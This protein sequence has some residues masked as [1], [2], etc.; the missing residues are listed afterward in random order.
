MVLRRSTCEGPNSLH[1]A[2][3]WALLAGVVWLLL[4]V[5]AHAQTKGIPSETYRYAFSLY[6]DGNYKDA[7]NRFQDEWRSANKFGQARWIDSICYHTM[8]GECNYQ[9]GLLPQALENYTAAIHLFL[10]YS[11]WMTRVQFRPIQA[12]AAGPQAP[13]G[14][15]TRGSRMGHYP[16]RTTMILGRVD[17]TLQSKGIVETPSG[18]PVEVQEIVRCTVLAIRRRAELLGPLSRYDALNKTLLTAV[19]QPIGPRNHWAQVYTDMELA[20]ALM[21]NGKDGEAVPV[22]TRSTVAGGEYDHP[23]T[24]TALLLLGQI[25]LRQGNNAVAAKAFFE[26]TI[27]AFRSEDL[28]SL[29]VIEE[30][31]HGASAA[32]LAANKKGMYPPLGPAAQWAQVKKWR[33]LHATLLLAAAEGALAAGQTAQANTMLDEAQATMARR[34]MANGRIGAAWNYL[35]AVSFFQQRKIDAGDQALGAAMNYLRTGSHWLFHIAQVDAAFASSLLTSR[36]ALDLYEEVLRDPQPADWA[37]APA[38]SLAVLSTPHGEA[39]ERWFL[40]ALQRADREA[41]V[42]TALEISDRARRHRFFSTLALGGRLQALR[43]VLEAPAEALDKKTLA[44]RLDLLADF[45]AYQALQQQV[46]QTQT[47]LAKLPLAPQDA[48]AARQQSALFAE[49]G[50]LSVQQEAILR[51]MA[52]RRQPADLVFPPVRPTEAIQKVLPKGT[53]VWAFF[54]AGNRLHA[55]LLNREK[56]VFW[57][58]KNVPTL[59]KRIVS[60]LQSMGN[61]DANRELTLKELA[62]TQWRGSARQVLELLLEGSQ[63][64]FTKRF[65]ELVI[66]PDGSLWYVPFEALQVNADNR[67]QPLI[68]RF[69]LRYAPTVSLAVSDGRVRRNLP[70]TAVALGRLYPRDSDAAAAAGAKEIANVAPEAAVF[71]RPP[72][73]AASFLL[74]TQIGQLIVLDDLMASDRG[75]YGWAPIQ[76]ERGKPGNTLNDWLTLPW[77]GP[78]VVVLPGFHTA[79]ENAMRRVPRGAAGADVFLSVCGLMSS[80][81]RTLFLSRWRTGGQSSVDLTRE[82]VQELPHVAPSDAWQRA[83]IV[84]AE[85][86]L[87]LDAEPRIKKTAGDEAPKGNHPFFWAS[88][89]LVDP[90]SPLSASDLEAMKQ[91]PKPKDAEPKE[92]KKPGEKAA[93][94]KA[95]ESNVPARPAGKQ[96]GMEPAD[97]GEPEKAS[98]S[99]SSKKAGVKMSKKPKPPNPA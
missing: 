27:A 30:A 65:P 45:P 55:F 58:V 67:L 20:V 50:K 37:F 72:L 19:S 75:P 61:Y 39:Y 8:I 86:R 3:G 99:K 44:Q 46:R 70:K 18:Y 79:A 66:V 64:D 42:D 95:D 7:L 13:W 82:F 98:A 84:V 40:A 76:V 54:W 33:E 24:S 94:G 97:D 49:L 80:G 21:A 25:A 22:L 62:D 81:A 1:V 36:S 85:N 23:L 6:Y 90:G 28:G 34:T 14:V 60:L 71:S 92:A 68:A 77:G 63:A 51:E 11:N 31:F 5:S 96:P 89:M 15:S 48:D 69:H 57:V 88:C 83:V 43:W 17:T 73:P 26:A 87:N 78:D 9:M 52:V 10:T 4:P 47:Q 56:S 53:A 32:H 41:A 91:P 16:Q 38:E 29:G 2:A 12:A 59:D 74:K 93:P 35:R